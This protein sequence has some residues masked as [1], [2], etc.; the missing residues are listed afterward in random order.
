[1]SSNRIQ[2][3]SKNVVL[4]IMLVLFAAFAVATRAQDQAIEGSVHDSSGAAIAGA[5]VELQTGSS[6][7]AVTTDSSGKFSF[8]AVTAA[9]G[10]LTVTAE[11]MEPLTQ[12]WASSS[13]QPLDLVMLPRTLLQQVVVTAARTQTRLGD[14]STGMIQ[15]SRQELE[16][17]PNFTLDDSLRQ[18]PGFSLFRRSSSRTANPTTEG[19]SL[20]GTGASGASRVLVLNDGIPLNDP[21]GGWIDWDRVPAEAIASVEVDQEGASSLYGSNALGGVVQVLT[22]EP[23]PAGASVEL[24]YGNQ[25]SPDLSAWAGGSYKGWY[26]TGDTQLFHTDGYYLV[27][28]SFRGSVDTKAN[29]EY[30]DTD[31][32]I[33]R[34][35]GQNSRLFASGSYLNESRNNGTQLQVNSTSL[36]QGALGADLDLGRAGTLTLRFY[37]VFEHYY[38]TFSSVAGNQNSESLTNRQTVPSQGVGGSVV[39]SRPIGQ[40]QTLVAGY[41]E[42]EEIGHSNEIIGTV[43]APTATQI[44]G[45]RQRSVGVFGED[46]IQIAP[47]WTL[48][49]SARFDDWRNFDALIS[50]TTLSTGAK[51]TTVPADL[52]YNAFSPRATLVHQFNE[53]I[54]W[55]ASV[56]RSFRAPTLNELYR[57]FRVGATTTLANPA[58]RAEH[59]TGGET[60]VAVTGFNRR[61]VVRGTFFYNQMVDPIA[62]VPCPNP[63]FPNSPCP[64]NPPANT[65]I[66]ANLGRTSAPGFEIDATARFTNHFDLSAGYQYV[67]AMVVSAPLQ[68]TL[69]NTPIQEVPHNAL[70]FQAH[71]SN[72]RWIELSFNGRFLGEQLDTTGATLGSVFI[73]DAMASHG[74]GDGFSIFAA[75]ENLFNAKY[76]T[77]ATTF[78]GS[79]VASPPQLGL[80]ITARFGVRFDFPKR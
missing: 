79:A 23:Q 33:G 74:L 3:A 12:S 57:Q 42:H 7:S 58:L 75:A 2:P 24:A 17:T 22:R 77:A 62:N 19:V 4:V 80:P 76:Y 31:L 8:P 25:H 13:H 68:P 26:A 43:A 21:F 54:S 20:R 64:A 29:S 69:L 56:Y 59:L 70:T 53:H 61:L 48:G 44:G 37:G 55:S 67:N 60:G 47:G 28:E 39:W 27:P 6:T 32:T 36:G 30:A 10:K 49:L 41:D 52:S 18:V 50:R 51:T 38:Q 66:R 14:T 11:G 78:S 9:E 1:M 5:Q 40:R 16:A 15:L 71:F 35:L 65:Q 63:P 34:K 45:G 73:A 72:P 46:L